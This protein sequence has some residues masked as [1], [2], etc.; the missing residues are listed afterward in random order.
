[1]NGPVNEDVFQE[2]D[3]LPRVLLLRIALG[4]VVVGLSLCIIAYL[5]LRAREYSLQPSASFSGGSLPP[6]HRVGQVREELFT[7]TDPKPTPLD[8]QSKTLQHYG[9]IDRSRGIVHVP[10]DVG[11]DLVLAERRGGKAPK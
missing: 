10:I 8:E 5:L 4:T 6:P 1:M 3:Q 7:I 2:P 11:M 9:W